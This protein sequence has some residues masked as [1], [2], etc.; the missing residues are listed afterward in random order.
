MKNLFGLLVLLS[1]ALIC[2][3]SKNANAQYV[4][5]GSMMIGGGLSF[6]SVENEGV[7]TRPRFP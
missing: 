2:F 4:N 7:I 5:K 6:T 3:S 1:F